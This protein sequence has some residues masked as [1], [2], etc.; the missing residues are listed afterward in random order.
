MPKPQPLGE[1]RVREREWF[2]TT[3]WSVVLAARDGT[4]DQAAEA[5]ERLCRTYWPPLFSYL[6][7]DGYGPEDAE[8]LAQEFFARL[9]ERQYLQRLHH[10]DGR[11][12]SFLLKFLKHFLLEKR[13]RAQAQK[14]GGGREFISLD[15]PPAENPYL[16]EPVTQLTPDE[17]YE[18]RWAQ[19]LMQRTYQRLEDE[20]IAAGKTAIYQALQ[21]FQPRAQDG[22]SYAAIGRRLGLSEPALK[23]AMQR[24]R[25]RHR[26]I[27]REEVAHTVR[28]TEEID[29][30]LQYLQSVLSRGTA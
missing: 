21:G 16:L 26:E 23:S 25:R 28:Q 3:H 29:E 13:G 2:T 24:L 19:A 14:R 12:R 22:E 27:L 6:R 20:Y 9:I 8:D 5:L 18:R 30:E 17:V 15:A 1:S 11:F 7:R 4:P 10:Q